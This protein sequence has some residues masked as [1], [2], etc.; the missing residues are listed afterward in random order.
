MKSPSSGSLK[1]SGIAG[2]L[3]FLSALFL[4]ACT[5][6][7][8]LN[9]KVE[10]I[11]RETAY[12]AKLADRERDNELLLILAFSGGG[13][14]AAALSYGILEALDLVEITPPESK[15]GKRHTLLDEV[16]LI[17]SVSGGSFTAAYYGLHGRDLFNDFPRE[18]LYKDYQGALMWGLANPVNW[19]LLSSPRYGRS[20]LA[21]EYYDDNLFKGATMGDIAKRRGP[22]ILIL[23][24]EAIDGISFSFT[25]SQ[26]ALICSDFDRFP[27]SR[28]VAASAAFPGAFSPVVLKNYSGTCGNRMP[29]WMEQ[30]LAKPDI[31]D[32]TY[33][34]ARRMKTYLDPKRKP[35]LHLIDGGVSDNLGV[36]GFLE[37][38][39]ARGGVR[40]AMKEANLEKIRRAAIIV[41][42][43]QTEPTQREGLDEVPGFTSVLGSSSTIMI[44]KYNF[45]T[46]ELLNHVARDWTYD[47]ETHG[48]KSI[49]FYIVH[50]A[51]D[52]IPDLEEQD[53]FNS[54]PTSLYLPEEQVD[55]LRAVAA[56]LLYND[57][58]FQ[59]LV[60]DLGGKIPKV[61]PALPRKDS[62]PLTTS[63]DS[64]EWAAP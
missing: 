36:R 56:T 54:I 34:N 55:R 26:F 33:Y 39:I 38:L 35:Y 24:T 1:T 20:D 40:E 21:Q 23:A 43:A 37:S 10:K 44:N 46:I 52:A 6:Q 31:T 48:R 58:D 41:V 61:S 53:Y 50:V 45:E 19:V 8:P 63:A 49:D 30:A 2:L 22:V 27:V 47:D 12:R 9:P 60:K 17:S 57:K 5:A 29:H 3:V 51:F 42:D 14:R 59:K 32:R 11:D 28:A 62:Q 16:D 4:T 7:Y 13:T 64:I 25:P 15:K 18:F